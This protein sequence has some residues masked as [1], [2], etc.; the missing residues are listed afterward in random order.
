MRYGTAT[1]VREKRGYVTG[2]QLHR[3]G[4]RSSAEVEP[5]M[6]YAERIQSVPPLRL[7]DITS[8]SALPLMNVNNK[9]SIYASYLEPMR[10][11]LQPLPS[12]NPTR[13]HLPSRKADPGRAIMWLV[14]T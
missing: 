3:G 11:F 9:L 5:G 7:L 10:N 4:N 8:G 2:I 6:L 13:D 1:H 12:C 14:L